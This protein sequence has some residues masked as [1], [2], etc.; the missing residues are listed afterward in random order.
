MRRENIPVQSCIIHRGFH[1]CQAV[2]SQSINNNVH[3]HILVNMESATLT[4]SWIDTF[5]ERILNYQPQNA[6]QNLIKILQK[7]LICVVNSFIESILN[8]G[9]SY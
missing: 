9:T 5:V 3:I 8:H 6:Y 4:Y 7:Q 2:L 1:R